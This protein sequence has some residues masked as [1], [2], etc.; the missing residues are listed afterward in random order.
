MEILRINHT[1]SPDKS[2]HRLKCD[3]EATTGFR[4]VECG[5]KI[6]IRFEAKCRD[7]TLKIEFSPSETKTL[8]ESL[9]D[10]E[11]IRTQPIR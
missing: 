11:Q 6:G 8:I 5:A 4:V 2:T 7:F 9:K 10:W 3:H 1:R